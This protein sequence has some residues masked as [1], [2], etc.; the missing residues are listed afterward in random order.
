MAD[1]KISALTSLGTTP[2]SGDL[3]VIVDVSDTTMGGTG[4]DKKLAYSVLDGIWAS[5]GANSDITSLSGLT[6]PL[7]V[8]Q[9]GTG[10]AT[11]TSGSVLVGNGTS[12]V[13][14]YTTTGSGTVLVLATSPTLVTPV[15]GVA[16][17]TSVNGLTLT[18]STGVI[19]ITNAKTLTVSDST[20]L[21]TNAITFGGTE[22]LTLTATK[23]VTFADAFTTSG[24]NPLTLTT[25]G[26]TNVTLPTTGTLSTL[27]GTETISNKRIT[28]RVVTVTQSATPTI[29][30][31]NTDVAYI[32]GLAQAIT[33]MTSSLSG[34]PVNGDS[35]IISITDNGTARGITWGASFES[36]GNVTL[37]STTVLGVRLDVGFLWNTVT[38]KWRCVAVA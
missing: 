7:S 24:A 32:T 9:G 1:T 5:Q 38:S 34:T 4:T 23:N 28:K 26:S 6:T 36:S 11:L 33:S 29:N 14:L 25:S 13:S 17:A 21:A 35:L 19:T 10:S 12:A 15:L 16:T 3:F 18:S 37:P 2:D 22:V 8:A 27:A 20:T 30:T 31:D